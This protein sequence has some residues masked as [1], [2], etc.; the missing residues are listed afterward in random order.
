MDFDNPISTVIP[1]SPM[2]LFSSSYIL[3]SA[4]L[5]GHYVWSAALVGR[6]YILLSPPPFPPTLPDMK[7]MHKNTKTN[8]FSYKYRGKY[9]DK[10]RTFH[11]NK[12]I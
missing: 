11:V 1:P 6:G 10:R 12:I 5:C 8:M 7:N 3:L 9:K 4:F 2:V